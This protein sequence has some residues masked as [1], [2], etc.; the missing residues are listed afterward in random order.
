MNGKNHRMGTRRK[1]MKQ[2]RR[3]PVSPLVLFALLI[4]VMSCVIVI[5]LPKT[6]LQRTRQMIHKIYRLQRQMKKM[7]PM[8]V[9]RK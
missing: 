6:D 1:N 8:K 9:I 4:V 3:K 7:R 2:K 5:L